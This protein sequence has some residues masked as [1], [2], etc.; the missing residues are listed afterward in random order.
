M[1]NVFAIDVEAV[2]QLG[3][4]T[5]AARTGCQPFRPIELRQPGSENLSS[6]GSR[7]VEIF[8]RGSSTTFPFWS[9]VRDGG[10]I[11]CLMPGRLHRKPV[12]SPSSSSIVTAVS[13]GDGEVMGRRSARIGETRRMRTSTF[14]KNYDDHSFVSR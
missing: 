7:S 12:V 3:E 6:I 2:A 1:N 9:Q 13:G 14:R 10:L 4:A 5:G 8:V 11:C